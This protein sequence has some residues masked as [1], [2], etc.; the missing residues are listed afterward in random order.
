[1]IGSMRPTGPHAP[2][3]GR[4]DDNRQ[5]KK[6]AGDFKP[7]YPAYAHEG[8]EKSTETAGDSTAG[9]SDGGPGLPAA[10]CCAGNRLGLGLGWSGS[11]ARGGGLG[12]SRKPLAGH[13][14]CDPESAS[15]DASNELS[16]HSIYDG[17]SDARRD[18]SHDRQPLSVCS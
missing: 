11:V 10:I 12:S 3:I 18:A 9:L 14:A 7:Q 1:M 2:E 4:K 8:A 17:S 13:F 15:Q 16:S 5:Q 6:D